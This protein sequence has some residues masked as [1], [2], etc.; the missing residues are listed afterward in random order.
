MVEGIPSTHAERIWPLVSPL[1]QRVVSEFDPGYSTDDLL[2][3]VKAQ[4]GQLWV[5]ATDTLHAAAI[6][7]INAYPEYKVLHAPYVAGDD[8]DRWLVPL[9][10]VFEAYARHHGCAYVTGCGRRGWVKALKPYGWEE[11]FTIVRKQL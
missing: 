5:C 9:L 2:E 3:K 10:D 7:E 6:T 1:F 11:G 8:M 4:K